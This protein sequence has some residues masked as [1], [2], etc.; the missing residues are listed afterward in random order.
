MRSIAFFALAALL[1]AGPAAAGEGCGSAS[2][3]VKQLFDQADGDRNGGLDRAEY[4][5]A[6]LQEFGA[7]FEQSD[8]NGDGVTS[9]EEYLDLYERTHSA[10]DQ[11]DV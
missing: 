9:L 2:A 8:A 3:K 4:D 10:T 7:S 5:G 1:A 11:T 6:G